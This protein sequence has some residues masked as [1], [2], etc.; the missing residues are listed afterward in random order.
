MFK[1]RLIIAR[2]KIKKNEAY[3]ALNFLGFTKESPET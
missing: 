3:A 2:R 1:D